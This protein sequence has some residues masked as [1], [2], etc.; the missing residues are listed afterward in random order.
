MTTLPAAV[1]RAEAAAD[2]KPANA[3]RIH[4]EGVI[5][6]WTEQFVF[7]RLDQ[8]KSMGAN[9]I[10]LEIDS[11]G[12]MVDPSFAIAEHLRDIDWA[13]TVA[14]V[15]REALSGA[16]FVALGCDEI[17]MK[18]GAR[19]GDA[20]PIIIGEDSMFR[21]APEKIVSDLAVRLRALAEA[22]KRPP[23]LAEAM[24][25]RNLEVFEMRNKETD[26]VSFLSEPEIGQLDHPDKWEKGKL[27]FESRKDHFLEV[28]GKRAVELGLASA[29]V[30]NEE[31]LYKLLHLQGTPPI[32]KQ[33]FVDTLVWILNIPFVTVLVLVIGLICLY[34]ELHI[35]GFGIAG[36][37]SALCFVLF[38]W[39]R[40]LGGTAGWLE[41]LLF[42]GGIIFVAIELFVLP[43]FGVTGLTGVLLILSSIILASQTFVIPHTVADFES[44]GKT[45][46]VLGA[47]VIVT[48]GMASF[49]GKYFDSL[50]MFRRMVLPPPENPESA[51]DF[52]E[53]SSA[54]AGNRGWLLDQEG[55]A[56]T[57]LRPA[58][59]ASF[60]DETVDVVT[61]GS[62]ISTGSRVRVIS[63]QGNRVVVKEV[64]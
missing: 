21:H 17:I 32:L 2:D 26:A 15:P 10:I 39:S 62:F 35:P 6:P 33:N 58:G 22:K 52:A 60:R 3:V 5:T 64:G 51:E 28:V 63:V 7:R 20:G 14:Y 4:F 19:L 46:M 37:A 59:K 1:R 49:L 8:A 31:D 47:S 41:V 29:V 53:T 13:K 40:M 11:P 25:N 34:V 56:T 24:V 42:F 54:L 44:L 45:A 18:P 38:F 61:E 23:A 57:F 48:I 12:G 30:S 50:P 27:V 16:A 9:V 55:I 43:G 36:I